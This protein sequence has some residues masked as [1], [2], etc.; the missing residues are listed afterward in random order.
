[1]ADPAEPLAATVARLRAAG[2]VFAEQEAALLHR[3]T[4]DPSAREDLL[5][6]R[7][8]GEPLEHVLGL[9]ELD[10]LR[11]AVAPGVFV[12]R[13]RTRFLSRPTVAA[14]HAAGDAPVMVEA[15]AGVAP[16]ATAVARALRQARVHAT[17]IDPRAAALARE[18]LGAAGRVHG[19]DL[20]APL[21]AGLRGRIDVIAAVVPY[22]PADELELLPREAREAEPALALDGG[23]EGLTVLA[24]LLDQAAEWLAPEGV[25]LTEIHEGQARRASGLTERAGLAALTHRAPDGVTAVLEARRP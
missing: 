20:L 7:A 24:R 25:L 8:A 5:R 15:C 17:E 12:P 4:P 10:G 22:V 16:V 3:E 2:C 11:L 21:P 19:G 18:N 6:R 9:V 14:C 13:Q 1:M 23:P